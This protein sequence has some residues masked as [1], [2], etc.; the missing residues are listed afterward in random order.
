MLHQD[1][2]NVFNTGWHV[3]E[4]AKGV[5]ALDTTPFVDQRFA[6]VPAGTCHPSQTCKL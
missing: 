3:P 2:S 6:S 5:M 4:L 1:K